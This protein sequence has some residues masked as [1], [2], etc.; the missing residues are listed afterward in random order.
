MRGTT[1][2]LWKVG[3]VNSRATRASKIIA[4]RVEDDEKT[5]EKEKGVGSGTRTTEEGEEDE[6]EAEEEAKEEAE[7]E[8]EDASITE[9]R[10]RR[11]GRSRP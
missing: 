6:E 1:L 4:S 3:R 10:V 9:I 2:L 7:E 5:R 11:V 8:E